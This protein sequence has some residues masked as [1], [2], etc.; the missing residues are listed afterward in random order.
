MRKVDAI[1]TADWHIREDKPI[2]RVDDFFQTLIGKMNFVKKLQKKFN[3]PVLNGGDLFHHWKPSPFLLSQTIKHLP[4]NFKTVYGN[5]D[6]PQHNL[7]LKNKSGVYVLDTALPN[8]DFEVL[9]ETSWG[10]TP[11]VNGSLTI[12]GRKILVW[13]KFTYVGEIPFPDCTDPKAL[14]LVHRYKDFDL[15]LTGDNHQAFTDEV[16]G[17]L[18]V[19]PGSLMRQSS[20][21]IDFTPRVYLYYADD[22][23]VEEVLIPL[24]PNAVT[25]EHLEKKQ[26]RDDRIDAFIEIL[27]KDFEEMRDENVLDFE[28]SVDVYLR[29][30][31]V[32]K[33]VKSIIAEVMSDG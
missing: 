33:Q 14:A 4:K 20:A 24:P 2:G 13:H 9:S 30:N 23:T 26:E 28:H 5:H 32:R 27:K 7:E 16:D 15:I 22:N 29:S 1:L 6:L 17:T 3:C 10:Q 19:N 21:Q 11:S 8:S 12:K 25:R 31:R 18:L